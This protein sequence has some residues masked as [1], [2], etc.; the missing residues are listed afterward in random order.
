VS[1]EKG[2]WG[3]EGASDLLRGHVP[4]QPPWMPGH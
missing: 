1:Y 2:S 4:W 3:P